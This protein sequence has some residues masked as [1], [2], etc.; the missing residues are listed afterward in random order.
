LAIERSAEPFTL[1]VVVPVLFA[2]TGSVSP[3]DTEA[4]FVSAPAVCGVTTIVTVAL[5][6]LAIVPRLHVTVVVPEQPA[7]ADFSVTLVGSTSVTVTSLAV[8]G[9]LLCAVSV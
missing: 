3:P 9:P 5:L 7:D 2:G 1:V 6:L 4:V 8:L